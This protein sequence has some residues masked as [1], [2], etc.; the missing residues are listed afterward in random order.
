MTLHNIKPLMP[1]KSN[2]KCA[3]HNASTRLFTVEFYNHTGRI[4]GE[5]EIKA[6][7]IDEAETHFKFFYPKKLIWR[8]YAS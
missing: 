4:K 7:N 5:T 3:I 8:V 2:E 1:M 6:R